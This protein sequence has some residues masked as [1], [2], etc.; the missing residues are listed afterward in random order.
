MTSPREHR[1]APA[2]PDDDAA[3]RHL[4]GL[5]L[6]RTRLTATDGS[7]VDLAAVSSG[8][9]VLFVYPRTG[10]PGEAEPAGWHDIPGAVGCTAEACGFRDNLQALRDAGASAVYGLSAQT[11]EY[12][13]EAAERLHLPYPLL[14]DEGLS[15]VTDLG[16]PTFR[17]GDLTLFK[18]LTLIVSGKTIEQV[19]Y[20]V[21]PAETHAERVA[22]WLRENP[23][24]PAGSGL[25]EQ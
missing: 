18:R 3:I 11:T 7:Q 22:E 6:P 10:V 9:W 21:F 25:L 16:L 5:S 14:S 17:A 12:Q 15:L 20:P 19:F 24:V 13:R 8:R 1:S 2:T 23:V 4:P